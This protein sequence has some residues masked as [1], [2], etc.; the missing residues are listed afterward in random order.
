MKNETLGIILL[1]SVTLAIIAAV[2]E[3]DLPETAG[4]MYSVAGLVYLVFGTWAGF[5]LMNMDK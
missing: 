4:A 2:I 5:R 3:S 1:A